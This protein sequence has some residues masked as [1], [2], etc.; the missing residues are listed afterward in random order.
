M[1]HAKP[2]PKS[3]ATVKCAL[4]AVRRLIDTSPDPIERRIAYQIEC[5]LRWATEPGIV[6]WPP[7]DQMARNATALLRQEWQRATHAE[8]R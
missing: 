3:P 1:N 7:P 8:P 6:G 4:R 5:A 2:T